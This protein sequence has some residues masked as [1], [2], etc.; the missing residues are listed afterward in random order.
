MSDLPLENIARVNRRQFF[1]SAASGVGVAAL[2]S[3]L[4]RDGAL[5]APAPAFAADVSPLGAGPLQVVAG[6]SEETP[7]AGDLAR[8]LLQATAL[9]LG[10]DQ[11]STRH[12]D[13]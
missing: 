12:I 10:D 7:R 13:L 4:Q 2:A 11:D 6:V 9:C 5:A 1:G 3:L 8:A